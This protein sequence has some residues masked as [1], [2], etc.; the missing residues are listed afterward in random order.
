MKT[1]SGVEGALQEALR[2]TTPV[3]PLNSFQAISQSDRAMKM[4]TRRMEANIRKAVCS[5]FQIGDCHIAN[6]SPPTAE[7]PMNQIRNAQPAPA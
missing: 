4:E 6:H 5:P 1:R 3:L 2:E 7:K